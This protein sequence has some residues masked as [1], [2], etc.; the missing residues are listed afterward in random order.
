M[1]SDDAKLVVDFLEECRNT[2][3]LQD[4][5][6]FKQEEMSRTLQKVGELLSQTPKGRELF[7]ELEDIVMTTLDLAKDTYFEY[8]DNFAQVRSNNFFKSVNKE[9][10]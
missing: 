2:L 4:D 5:F 6:H 1:L 9:V 7:I 8:G 3:S 10:V